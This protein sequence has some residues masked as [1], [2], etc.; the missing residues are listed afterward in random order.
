MRNHSLSNRSREI[1][2]RLSGIIGRGA[3]MWERITT[4]ILV[5][6]SLI[7]GC[8]SDK[9]SDV[10]VYREVDGKLV[11][12]SGHCDLNQLFSGVYQYSANN[13]GE[14][15]IVKTE[16]LRG[17][18]NG[19]EMEWLGSFKIPREASVYNRGRRHGVFE[20][21][22]RNGNVEEK[23][24][25][26]A[27]KLNGLKIEWWKNGK[28]K[29]VGEYSHGFKNGIVVDWNENGN[30]SGTTNY[31]LD[32]PH[33]EKIEWD[34][35]GRYLSSKMLC[36]GQ[37]CEA[38]SPEQY[39]DFKKRTQEAISRLKKK[40]AQYADNEMVEKLMVGTPEEEKELDREL[41]TSF[42]AEELLT[43]SSL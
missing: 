18:K 27:G 43:C 13:V 10:S 25:Y 4:V 8:S 12:A 24:L 7:A 9:P 37:Q 36:K 22:F 1:V 39:D 15:L 42:K 31:F 21:W 34:A 19:V 41:E 5:T 33:G 11:S 6:M 16:Y 32:S 14:K 35:A 23:S 20:R 26:R 28:I 29:E 30:L 17:M 2:L 38:L 40:I 3:R